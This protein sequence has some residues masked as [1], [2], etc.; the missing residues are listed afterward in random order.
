MG[1]KRDP[2]AILGVDPTATQDEIHAAW[3]ALAL[4]Y[5]PDLFA[6]GSD[7]E[8]ARAEEAMK[9]VNEAFHAIRIGAA[10]PGGG[11]AGRAS[12]PPPRRTGDNWQ[13]LYCGAW[14][15]VEAAIGR[16]WDC[17]WCGV[18]VRHILC[19]RGRGETH[20]YWWGFENVYRCVACGGNHMRS[21]PRSFLR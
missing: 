1:E 8:R 2:Y 7:V 20:V 6:E 14:R 9:Q 18:H 3:R 10:A 12:D 21:V 16:R 5:H 4:T 17:D 11:Y 13:C 19:P 15:F